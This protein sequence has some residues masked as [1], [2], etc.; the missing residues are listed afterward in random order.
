M[1]KTEG[2]GGYWYGYYSVNIKC[3]TYE[4]EIIDTWCMKCHEDMPSKSKYP[5][6]PTLRYLTL[7]REGARNYKLD[8]DY[9]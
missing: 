5:Y 2:G 1:Q 4:G 6:L 8:Q 7:I 9:I 3:Q